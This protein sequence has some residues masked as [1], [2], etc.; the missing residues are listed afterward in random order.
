MTASTVYLITRLDHIV[1]FMQ[2]CF[3]FGLVWTL[4][5]ALITAAA[6]S[7]D[8]RFLSRHVIAISCNL[9]LPPLFG[10]L[11]LIGSLFVPNTKEACAIYAIP[12]IANNE[13]AKGEAKEVYELAKAWLAKQDSLGL[14][15]RSVDKGARSD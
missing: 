1:L 6:S 3:A 9:A 10:L 12:K 4:L 8:A 11:L 13:A 15:G 5:A 14:L 7:D 2:L